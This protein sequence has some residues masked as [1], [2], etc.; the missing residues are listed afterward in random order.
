MSSVKLPIAKYIELSPNQEAAEES[1]IF[2]IRCEKPLEGGTTGYKAYEDD[3]NIACRD[4]VG[5]CC[6]KKC[7]YLGKKEY[8]GYCKDH[9][10]DRH[11]I[12]PETPP[13][14]ESPQS[15]ALIPS[16]P[17]TTPPEAKEAKEEKKVN[18]PPTTVGR[19]RKNDGEEEEKKKT[20]RYASCIQEHGED[21]D[22]ELKLVDCK[23]KCGM[24]VCQ[25]HKYACCNTKCDKVYCRNCAFAEAKG[26][27]ANGSGAFFC[28]EHL[29]ETF[30]T[31]AEGEIYHN[32][33]TLKDIV[34]NT[35]RK[36]LG[37]YP[38]KK[39]EHKV[40]ITTNGLVNQQKVTVVEHRT[41]QN[42]VPYVIGSS[43][44]C[45]IRIIDP[46]VSRW[47]ALLVITY[48]KLNQ[49]DWVHV[50]ELGSL[51]GTFHAGDLYKPDKDDECE[52]LDFDLPNNATTVE[53]GLLHSSIKFEQ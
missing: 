20:V 24:T 34:E 39:G 33:R 27:L 25:Q 19:K 15:P 1:R 49:S 22:E 12:V 32:A 28:N 14:P 23:G 50:Y 29:L 41:L 44:K 35:D 42:G 16:L 38:T 8:N 48:N 30:L 11:I 53:F 6:E 47:H 2:C 40:M 18:T 10:E 13:P 36:H 9:F 26:A 52:S 45:D 43:E 5:Y 31:E 3:P 4:C 21:Q 51:N 7:N 46:T 37:T 17:P